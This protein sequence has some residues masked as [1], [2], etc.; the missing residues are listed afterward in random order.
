MN[1]EEVV[2]LAGLLRKLGEEVT[3]DEEDTQAYLPQPGNYDFYIP[4]PIR[5]PSP[6][7]GDTKMWRRLLGIR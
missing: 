5:D 3:V 2:A 6:Y 7:T 4:K 1:P